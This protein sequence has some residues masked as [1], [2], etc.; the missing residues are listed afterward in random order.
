[1]FKSFEAIVGSEALTGG[2][3]GAIT[4][5]D[6]VTEV[7]GLQ[8]LLFCATVLVPVTL[9]ELLIH[10]LARC[11]FLVPVVSLNRDRVSCASLSFL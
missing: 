11:V 1:M 9:I 10:S 4:A 2:C 5:V 6:L 3:C 8:L 7:E